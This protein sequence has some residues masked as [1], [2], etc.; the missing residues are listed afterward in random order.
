[1]KMERKTIVE[2]SDM[3]LSYIK[4]LKAAPALNTRRIFETW[5]K[6]SG[7]S[8]YTLKLFFREG[9]LYVTLSS[10]VVRNSIKPF[11]NSIMAKI[12]QS[13]EE[14]PLFIKDDPKVGYVNKII[15]K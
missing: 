11:L 10:S 7:V 15:V 4:Y 5:H 6:E 13:L 12:N 8:A 3:M 9:T 14:D 2:S 1:M